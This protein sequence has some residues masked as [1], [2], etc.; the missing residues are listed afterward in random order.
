MDEAFSSGSY[1]SRAEPHFQQDAIAGEPFVIGNS[2][3]STKQ[4][5][6]LSNRG[7]RCLAQWV[8]NTN[9]HSLRIQTVRVPE[10]I[11]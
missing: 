3:S 2:G 9:A 8:W 4:T 5:A 7:T 1:E 11:S 6:H 10:I